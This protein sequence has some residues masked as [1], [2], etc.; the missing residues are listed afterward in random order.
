[1]K[2][3]AWK[4][5]FIKFNY[6]CSRT[7]ELLEEPKKLSFHEEWIDQI[8]DCCPKHFYKYRSFN[9]DNVDA[10]IQKKAWFSRPSAWNDPID[11]TVHYDLGKDI[12]DMDRD[13]DQLV[14]KFARLF[15]EKYMASYCDQKKTIDLQTLTYYYDSA[16]KGSDGFEPGRIVTALTPVVG[17]KVARQMA[18]KTSQILHDVLNPEFKE[19]MTAAFSKMYSLNDVRDTMIL[20]SLSETYHNNHQWAIYADGG[21]GFCIGYEIKPR[22]KQQRDLMVNLLPVYYGKKPDFSL[23]RMLEES[24]EYATRP[25]TFNDLVNQ[26]AEKEFVAM[27]TKDKEWQGEQEWRFAIQ[28]KDHPGSLIDFDFAKALYLG[29]KMSEE[30][31]QT[32]IK[33]GEQLG[34]S[35]YR[36][37]LDSTGS[38]FSYQKVNKKLYGR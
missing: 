33:V 10:L 24:I 8:I 1:M 7:F 28:D 6:K 37:K 15:I 4:L 2:S 36:R 25:E 17:D 23:E 3:E 30:N 26:E 13:F 34:I 16:F 20:C 11:V 5:N 22:T 31:A 35:V 21:K 32:L 27:F 38:E 14:L 29:D 9:G 19:N 12:A 18:A